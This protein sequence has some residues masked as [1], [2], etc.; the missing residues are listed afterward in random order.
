MHP[1]RS[2][3]RRR[4]SGV[5]KC[6]FLLLEVLI[7]MAFLV[8]VTG[9][10]VKL[11]KSRLDYDRSTMERLRQRLSLE[12]IA[13]SVHAMPYETLEADAEELAS[14]AGAWIQ[15]QPFTTG[16]RNGLHIEL[17]G[18]TSVGPVLHHLW[19]LEPES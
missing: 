13:E 5:E 15:I 16:N 4:S 18:E 9:I 1:V 17:R 14:D 12:N 2:G 7:A 6:G 11:H 8:I 10:A 19:R 3:F